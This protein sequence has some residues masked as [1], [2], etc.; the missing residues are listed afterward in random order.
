MPLFLYFPGQNFLGAQFMLTAKLSTYSLT[1]SSWPKSSQNRNFCPSHAA[2]E[3]NPGKVHSSLLYLCL[4]LG[5]QDVPMWPPVCVWRQGAV[6]DTSPLRVP[7]VN[8]TKG[9]L[10]LASRSTSPTFHPFSGLK[11]RKVTLG[12]TATPLLALPPCFFPQF[13]GA[14]WDKCWAFTSSRSYLPTQKQQPDQ[15]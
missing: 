11:P 3:G 2:Q 1:P 7:N 15:Y 8:L 10:L 5:C 4:M 12:P 6:Q 9:L 13:L 14:G